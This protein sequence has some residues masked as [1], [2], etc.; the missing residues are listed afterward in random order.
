[1]TYYAPGC[2]DPTLGDLAIH[3]IMALFRNQ[4]SMTS[5]DL[6]GRKVKQDEVFWA[7][8]VLRSKARKPRGRQVY[9]GQKDSQT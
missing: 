2:N 9:A 3:T 4:E 7:P 6:K 5:K 1:M 8:S